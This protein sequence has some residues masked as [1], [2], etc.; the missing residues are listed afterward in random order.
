MSE[1]ERKPAASL[2]DW[3]GQVAHR[4]GTRVELREWR[5][6]MPGETVTF[7]EKIPETALER[8]AMAGEIRSVAE[9]DSVGRPIKQLQYVVLGFAPTNSAPVHRHWIKLGP[10]GS[11]SSADD[12]ASPIASIV[13]GF[14]QML[15]SHNEL[16]GIALRAGQGRDEH[17]ER[18]LGLVL[19]RNEHLEGRFN[20]LLTKT[21]DMVNKQV[22]RDMLTRQYARAEKNDEFWFKKANQL[23]P[24]LGF[25]LLGG[26]DVKSGRMPSSAL[27]A[28]FSQVVENITPEELDEL[29]AMF[30]GATLTD[31][32]KMPF[33][34]MLL[35][36][37][38]RRKR[39]IN[40]D[41]GAP[42]AGGS[43]NGTPPAAGTNGAPS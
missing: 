23:M 2:A 35:A 15:K 5:A 34:Q 43:P 9:S 8:E 21:T 10:D 12:V 19:Q 30:D 38:A 40:D 6:N 36:I 11:S 4:G 28:L 17:W 33:M 29:G 22:E 14:N 37:A 26:G 1:E 24:I 32:T 7:W 13:A 39:K 42:P 3:L 41:N 31:E 25:R 27:E 20:E 16:H 18:L